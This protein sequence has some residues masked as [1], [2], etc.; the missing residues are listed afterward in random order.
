MRV[1]I[2]YSSRDYRQ[3]DCLRSE[4]KKSSIECWMAPESIPGGKNYADHIPMAIR[5]TDAFIVLLSASSMESYWVQNEIGY[6][7]NYKRPLIPIHLDKSA[8]T[9]AFK[10]ILVSSQIIET[11]GKIEKSMDKIREALQDINQQPNIT[12][13]RVIAGEPGQEFVFRSIYDFEQETDKK[14]DKKQKGK[15]HYIV[16]ALLCVLALA[17]VAFTIGII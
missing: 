5:T 8:L 9:E 17:G 13:D 16:I 11:G 1:F 2:S 4:L 7:V 10:F 15:K 3:A 12:S 6:A 14:E